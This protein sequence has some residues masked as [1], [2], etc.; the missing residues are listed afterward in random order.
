MFGVL[1]VVLGSDDIAGLDFS[2]GQRQIPLVASLRILK[3]LR[4]FA[5][6]IRIPTAWSGLQ[7][8]PP[9]CVGVNSC[10]SLG[11]FAWLLLGT[12]V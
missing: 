2:L 11:H 6:A 3:A 5:R 1:I 8:M 12:V 4:P 7:M 9:I 10:L